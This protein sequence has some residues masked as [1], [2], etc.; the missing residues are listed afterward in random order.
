MSISNV[1]IIRLPSNNLNLFSTSTLAQYVYNNLYEIPMGII[2]NS[3]TKINKGIIQMSYIYNTST[4]EVQ[5]ITT[6]LDLLYIL[7][8]WMRPT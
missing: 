8:F 2:N 1:Y 7:D 4:L 3:H 6:W 5:Y